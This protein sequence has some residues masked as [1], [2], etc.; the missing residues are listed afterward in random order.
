[1]Y[2]SYEV[3]GGARI[4]VK[5]RVHRGEKRKNGNGRARR[6]EHSFEFVFFTL[7]QERDSH[8]ASGMVR[9]HVYCDVIFSWLLRMTETFLHCVGWLVSF[10][11]NLEYEISSCSSNPILAF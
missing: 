4:A 10:I 1:M 5:N 8:K 6:G 2:A 3:R 11:V 9:E 7:L